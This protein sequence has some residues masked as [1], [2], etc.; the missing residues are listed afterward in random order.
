M[1][2]DRNNSKILYFICKLICNHTSLTYSNNSLHDMKMT[3]FA[4]KRRIEYHPE[5]FTQDDTINLFHYASVLELLVFHLSIQV[6]NDILSFSSQVIFCRKV[7][8]NVYV[9]SIQNNIL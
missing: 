8:G 3:R 5:V 1:I 7:N 6:K 9:Q 2:N 4:N